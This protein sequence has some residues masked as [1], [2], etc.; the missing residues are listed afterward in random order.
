MG[1]A[2]L[3][4]RLGKL[5]FSFNYAI[6]RFIN[7]ATYA[8]GAMSS[9]A[10]RPEKYTL[11]AIMALVASGKLKF[12]IQKGARPG[13]S[14]VTTHR[15]KYGTHCEKSHHDTNSCEVLHPE[16]KNG[17][18]ATMITGAAGVV[19]G[20]GNGGGGH[21][22]R[23]ISNNNSIPT[24]IHESFF[25]QQAAKMLVCHDSVGHDVVEEEPQCAAER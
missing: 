8:S 9:S 6:M 15:V 5:K 1:T 23:G 24:G 3:L 2:M 22:G 19:T 10:H 11:R 16:L 13:N 7:S 14:R 25:L 21:G 4:L 18:R 12:R 20:C 17:P